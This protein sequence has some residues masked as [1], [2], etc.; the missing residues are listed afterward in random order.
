MALRKKSWGARACSGLYPI[1]Q[2]PPHDFDLHQISRCFRSPCPTIGCA[3]GW[4]GQYAR[5]VPDT[6]S[7]PAAPPVIEVA[8]GVAFE[9][10]PDLGAV[11]L[12]RLAAH[13]QDEYPVMREVPGRPPGGLAPAGGIQIGT[14]A[15]PSRLWLLSA[16]EN[17]LVQLQNDTLIINW[18]RVRSEDVYPGHQ[19]L[20]QRFRH[21]WAEFQERMIGHGDLRPRLVEWTYVDRLESSVP[22]RDLTFVDGSLEQALPGVAGS[23]EFRIV[24][25]LRQGDKLEGYLAV[26]GG[27]ASAPGAEPF[28][29]LNITTKLDAAGLPVTGMGDLLQQA[30]DRS[31][32]AF[33]AVVDA[34]LRDEGGRE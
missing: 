12:A 4:M 9:P 5:P 15:P 29:A 17:D 32:E 6:Q 25:E 23:F 31:F 24:R 20:L 34:R 13:W 21:L 33:T 1:L 18:R 16:D 2:P 11:G 8:L 30:H 28:Y 19:E 10:L 3:P 27:P 7:G 26:V 22:A 14:G